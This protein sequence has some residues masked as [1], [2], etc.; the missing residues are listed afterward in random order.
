MKSL[1]K[2]LS[3]LAVAS[4]LSACP[5]QTREDIKKQDEE[6]QL[7]EQ[8]ASIQKNRADSEMKYT[9]IQS[10]L[11]ATSGRLDT[12][13]HNMANTEKANR[14]E[15]DGLRKTIEAQNEKIKI[16]EEHIQATEARVMAAL[17]AGAA[18]EP[19]VN[20]A[21]EG[22][23]ESASGG[24]AFAEAETLFKNK[25]FKKA[26]VKY[27]TYRDKSPKGKDAAEATYKI[28]V[29]FSELG[30]KRDA[31]E[32]FQ[33]TLDNYPGSPSAKKAKYRLSNL[34]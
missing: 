10:E 28:G 29:C 5:F 30:M 11:R 8:V 18:P 12:L 4:L 20:T 32:F 15:M 22:K 23:K 3:L 2:V 27:Q 14:Q 33:E 19:R 13:E 21:P 34:K 6:R 25:E 24:G 31:K 7:K 9:D 16:L 26:I 1:L 17:Q